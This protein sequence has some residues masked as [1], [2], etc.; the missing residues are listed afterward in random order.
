MRDLVTFVIGIVCFLVS[1]AVFISAGLLT[2]SRR[3]K[4]QDPSDKVSGVSKQNRSEPRDRP[5][6]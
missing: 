6:S 3:R 5:A 1:G 2:R 4:R